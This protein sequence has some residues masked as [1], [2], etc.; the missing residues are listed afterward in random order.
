MLKYFKKSGDLMKAVGIICEYNP[1]HNG[2]LYHLKKVRE[3]F[4]GY[5]IILVLG[6]NYTQRGEFSIIDKWKKTE[7]ALNYV[8]LV[9]ELPFVFAVQAA[10]IFA[11]GACEILKNLKVDAIVFG[12]E[13]D[14][15]SNLKK[16]VKIQE[17]DDYH[18][19]VNYYLD[20]GLNYPTALSKSL[21][22][23]GGDNIKDSNDLL[24]LGYVRNLMDS[25][26]II[27]TIKRT[28]DYNSLDLNL[29]Y[30][31]GTGIRKALREGIDVS[32]FVPKVTYDNLNNLHFFED[33]FELLKYKIISDDDLSKYQTVDEGIEGRIKKEI[34]KATSLDDLIKRVKSKR[35]TYAKINRMFLH[36]FVGFTK[37]EAKRF[38]KLEY[39]RVLGFNN[40]GRGYLK[41]IK[42]KCSLPIITKYS[43]DFPMLDLENRV[44]EIY[45]IKEKDDLESDYKHKPI[46]F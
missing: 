29:E 12:S 42:D 3:L 11:K 13:C 41:Y 27:K 44:N 34:Y 38:N 39:I 10:D 18:K 20:K 17:S 24:A 35:Y 31:S 40:K 8:D 7:I 9:I 28:N 14:N 6:G 45:N 16:M 1:M 21:E 23:L 33:Y 43:K 25:D 46:I 26:I 19:R 4:P 22:D 15:I 36:I 5:T 30:A 37:E 32:K 2:H